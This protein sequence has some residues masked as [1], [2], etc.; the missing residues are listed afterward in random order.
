MPKHDSNF[1]LH[2]QQHT[3]HIG[4]EDGLIALGGYVGSRTGSA[5]GASVIDGNVEAAE[6]S[7]GLVNK[8]LDFLFMPHIGAHKLGFSAEV[9][10]FSRELPTFI[11]VSTG[12]ND[13]RSFMREGQ[14]G[15]PTDAGQR[16]GN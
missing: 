8:V 10:Q 12:Y 3:K 5:Y 16:A 4:V 14:G 11:V 13:P 9:A 1:V 2:A 7:D 15:A 6:A